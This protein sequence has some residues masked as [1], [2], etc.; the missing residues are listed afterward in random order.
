MRSLTLITPFI[1]VRNAS[2]PR[3]G[4]IWQKSKLDS[5]ISAGTT[6]RNI[7]IEDGDFSPKRV[8]KTLSNIS[9]HLQLVF[10]TSWLGQ[11]FF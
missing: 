6:P 5:A 11:F 1:V 4:L 2:E 10:Q 3:F 9:T 7:R 8:F